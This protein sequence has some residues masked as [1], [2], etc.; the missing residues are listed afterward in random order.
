[1]EENEKKTLDASENTTEAVDK[2]TAKKE[3]IEETAPETEKATA[4]ASVSEEEN[5][6]PVDDKAVNDVI[7]QPA[8]EEK[9][10]SIDGSYN[11]KGSTAKPTD[12]S[13]FKP[14]KYVNDGTR[15]IDEDIEKTRKTF[16][17]KLGKSKTWDIVSIVLMII[18]F[19]GVIIV[20]FTNKGAQWITW[21]VIGIAVA[22]IIGSFVLASVFNKKN[23]KV[24]EEYLGVYEDI[25]NGYTFDGLGVADP[26]LCPDAK[27]DDQVIIQSHYFRVINS[28]QSRALVEGKRKGRNF[29]VAEVAVVIPSIKIEDANKK[30]TELVNLDDTPYVPSPVDSDTLTSTQELSDKDMT[31]VDLELA[32]EANG[33]SKE[34][35]KRRK[36]EEKAKKK[37]PEATE[38]STG[39]FGK[40]YSYDMNVDS[41]EAVIISFMGEKK[42][43]VLPNYLT[44]FEAV[45]VPG[46]RSNIVV[47]AIN[48][49]EASKFF[50]KEGVALLNEINVGLTIQSAFISLNSYGSK[51]G[52]T[53]SDDIMS[54][55]IKTA[56]HIGTMDE[57]KEATHQIF[58]FADYVDSKRKKTEVNQ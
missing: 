23:S 4:D 47:Y 33:N 38:T 54:L 12:A 24:A 36:D 55:P 10:D 5:K 44:G 19:V 1:M 37:N 57:F 31:M 16:M 20:T 22:I 13:Y 51:F 41:E 50:D 40:I 11:A 7:T 2:D 53:L 49:R 29:Q 14:I 6:A 58:D 3:T 17:A 28:I 52:L 35:D 42:Y 46:L 8:E 21:T 15:T 30:P 45:H 18:S 56:P 39:L 9:A 26:V 27:I 25:V 32:N 34:S 48:P 43:T